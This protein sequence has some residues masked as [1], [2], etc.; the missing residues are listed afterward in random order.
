MAELSSTSDPAAA[1]H[2]RD[3]TV[4]PEMSP[5]V[6]ARAGL[7]HGFEAG[8]TASSRAVRLDGR[9]AFERERIALSIGVGASAIFGAR[10]LGAGDASG[11]YG[12]GFDVPV[13]VGWRSSADLYAV[14][15][16]PRFGADFLSGQLDLGAP[17]AISVSGRHLHFG[18]VAG[19]RAGLR[20]LYG[21]LEVEVGYHDSGGTL[22]AQAVQ[23]QGLSVAPAGAL[24]VS[25]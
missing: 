20:R 10:S 25:F 8:L 13:L 2:L 17:G 4:A 23:L 22:G 19:L 14:W 24:V 6:F 11:V 16:G 5:W 12:G 15:A 3:L 18:G 7:G 1:A 21:V 9:R